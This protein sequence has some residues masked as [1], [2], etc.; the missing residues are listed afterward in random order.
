VVRSGRPIGG[1]PLVVLHVRLVGRASVTDQS[2]H[3]RELVV[4]DRVA[5]LRG[6]AVELVVRLRHP[7]VVLAGSALLLY[8]GHI[9]RPVLSLVHRSVDELEHVGRRRPPLREEPRLVQGLACLINRHAGFA[10]DVAAAGRELG[11]VPPAADLTARS[12]A[13]GVAFVVPEPAVASEEG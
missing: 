8:L 3:A 10:E 6:D 1:N 11:Q 9:S 7:L 12:I 2:A 5:V 13:K 4:A